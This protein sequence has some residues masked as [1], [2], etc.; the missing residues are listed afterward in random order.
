MIEVVDLEG[1]KIATYSYPSIDGKPFAFLTI[2]YS[3]NPERFTFLQFL[4]E[5]QSALSTAEP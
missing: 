1:K 2:C 4:D 3:E 5:N